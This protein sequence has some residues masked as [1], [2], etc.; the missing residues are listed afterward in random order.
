MITASITELSS[1]LHAKRLSSVELTQGLLDR[2]ARLDP[3]LNAFITV[4]PERALADAR[5][6]DAA[7]RRRQRRAR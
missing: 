2:I 3:V 7:H 1:A 4:D 5:A 6:A